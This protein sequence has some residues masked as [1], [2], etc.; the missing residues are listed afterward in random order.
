MVLYIY[1]Y[2]CIVR[3]QDI[4]T[5]FTEDT[6]FVKMKSGISHICEIFACVI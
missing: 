4:A 3:S 2:T 6:N 1:I 5:T